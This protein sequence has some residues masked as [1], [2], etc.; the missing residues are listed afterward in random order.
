ML[1]RTSIGYP[2]VTKQKTFAASEREDL[3]SDVNAF[4]EQLSSNSKV[5]G[6]DLSS[7]GVTI[8][9]TTDSYCMLYRTTVVWQEYAE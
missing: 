7:H 4:L 6:F 1:K 2:L 9:D 3:D 8:A 5:I